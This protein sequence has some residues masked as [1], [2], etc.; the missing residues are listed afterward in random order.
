MKKL[1][2]TLVLLCFTFANAQKKNNRII[3]ESGVQTTQNRTTESYDAVNAGGSFKVVL[4]SGKEGTIT[5][6][7]DE[8]IITH[9]VTEVT[10]NELQISFEKNL[11]ITY[12]SEITIT[13]PVEEIS[14]ITFAGS[15]DIVSK[16]T[17]N[18]TNFNVK[19]SGS[20]DVDI[21][22]NATKI[23]A[24]LSGSGDINITGKTKE[25]EAKVV[26]SGDIDCGKL[27]SENATVAVSGSG[28][29]KVNCTNNLESKV[30]GSGTIKYKNKPATM[31]KT[32]AGSGEIIAY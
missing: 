29:L 14:G 20:G 10:N 21:D 30:A 32:V 16:T 18:A 3:K 23:T 24:S 5:I 6:Q 19:L 7:G 8:N 31:N 17:L 13:V 2:L 15:G 9:I 25:L 27:V 28:D 1:A 4:V 22:V 26:G 11:S 12:R